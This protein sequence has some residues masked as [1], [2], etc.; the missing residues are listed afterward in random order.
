MR[1]YCGRGYVYLFSNVEETGGHDGWEQGRRRAGGLYNTSETY[2]NGIRDKK[3]R[4]PVWTWISP[5]ST[6]RV[7]FVPKAP[8][9]TTSLSPRHGQ[10]NYHRQ[11]LRCTPSSCQCRRR[12]SEP[13][14]TSTTL[15]PN[16]YT[17]HVFLLD[18]A[19][20]PRAQATS[21]IDIP[22][23]HTQCRAPLFD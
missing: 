19:R 20:P 3:G 14:S 1:G 11:S 13:H 23:H 15:P 21:K 10:V 18:R 8:C 16:P 2:D 9:L 17:C 22:T 7:S 6:S 4:T 5:R 12:T